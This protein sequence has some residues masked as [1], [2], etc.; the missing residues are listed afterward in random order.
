M[1]LDPRVQRSFQKMDKYRD[2]MMFLLKL[3]HAGLDE[4]RYKS[5]R[6]RSQFFMFKP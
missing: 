5:K 4:V 6:H 2:E 1:N 3:F